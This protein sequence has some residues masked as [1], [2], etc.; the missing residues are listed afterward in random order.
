MSV[1]LLGQV[2]GNSVGVVGK[3]VSNGAVGIVTS[4]D[5]D[6]NSGQQVVDCSDGRGIAGHGRRDVE[7]LVNEGVLLG[8]GD[9]QEEESGRVLSVAHV[10]NLE[11]V[12]GRD[13]AVGTLDSSV[14]EVK[15]AGRHVAVLQKG[16]KELLSLDNSILRA[17]NVFVSEADVVLLN[18]G[19]SKKGQYDSYVEVRH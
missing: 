3:H 5:G 9:S 16:I 19:E 12:V 14:A 17:A 13:I 6:A 7:V 8:S 4:V 10:V 15:N 1:V 18:G 2:A 11:Y